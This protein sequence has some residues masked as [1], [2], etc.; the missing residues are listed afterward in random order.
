[1]DE[2]AIAHGP[3]IQPEGPK[4]FGLHPHFNVGA[5]GEF[6]FRGFA[7]QAQHF[8]LLSLRNLIY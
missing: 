8:S 3:L 5:G 2:V 4:T 1:V 6:G 7:E